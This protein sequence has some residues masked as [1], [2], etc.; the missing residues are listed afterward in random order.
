MLRPLNLATKKRVRPQRPDAVAQRLIEPA[1]ERRHPDDRR[2]PDNHAEHRQR[3][4][5]LVDA[6]G[7]ERQQHD[8]PQQRDAE[9]LLRHSRLSASIGSRRAAREGGIQPEEKPDRRGDADAERDRPELEPAGSGVTAE[10][11]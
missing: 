6:K 9:S 7:V 10:I 2:D 1:D 5:Q 8:F 3:R 11:T 4:S